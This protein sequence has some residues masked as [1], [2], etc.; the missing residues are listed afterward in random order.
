LR[1]GI[2]ARS[3]FSRVLKYNSSKNWISKQEIEKKDL[4]LPHPFSR[5]Q[6][7]GYVWLGSNG[8]RVSGVSL[9]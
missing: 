1:V 6:R 8:H 4:W 2:L 3:A 5:R 9:P 7:V